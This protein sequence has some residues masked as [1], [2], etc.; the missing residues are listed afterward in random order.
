MS[1]I[2]GVIPAIRPRASLQISAG[3]VSTTQGGYAYV[4]SGLDKT[5]VY[6]SAMAMM[7]AMRQSGFVQIRQFRLLSR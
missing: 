4:M 7:G 2:P 1:K 5:Q 3:V 6:S